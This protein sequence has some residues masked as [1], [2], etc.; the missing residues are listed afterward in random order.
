MVTTIL[1]LHL[2]LFF[3]ILLLVCISKHQQF[4]L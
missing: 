3:F 1:L 2:R 4:L